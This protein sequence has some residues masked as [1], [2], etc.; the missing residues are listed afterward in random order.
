M[1][2][3]QSSL[4]GALPSRAV[5]VQQ[6]GLSQLEGMDKV[7]HLLRLPWCVQATME[8]Q[9]NMQ[10]KLLTEMRTELAAAKEERA[11]A[12]SSASTR[13]T[14]VRRRSPPPS[15][16]MALGYCP[17]IACTCTAS[18]NRGQM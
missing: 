7:R 3:W 15:R 10:Q 1:T 18:A 8:V 12:A 4:L 13:S 6:V 16:S 11:S 5:A 17:Q 2:I 9:L 14:Q